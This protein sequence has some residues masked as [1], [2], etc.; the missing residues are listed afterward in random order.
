MSG[1]DW[2]VKSV[3]KMLGMGREGLLELL[4]GAGFA[5]HDSLLLCSEIGIC[6]D[7]RC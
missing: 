7:A 3:W 2:V 5:V 6:G 4:D 1:E